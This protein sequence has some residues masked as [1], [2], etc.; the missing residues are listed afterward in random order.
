MAEAAEAL[1]LGAI[2]AFIETLGDERGSLI[3]VL[4][5]TQEKFGYLPKEAL[6][7]IADRLDV[8]L[9]SVVGV[10]TFYSQFSLTRRGRT[11]IRL[12]DGTAC[13]VS[14]AGKSIDMVQRTL[15]IKPGETSPDYEF[16]LE[17][18]YRLGACAISPVA[19]VNGQVLGRATPERVQEIINQQRT[20]AVPPAGPEAA[21]AGAAARA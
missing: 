15:K 20:P 3:P 18:V 5:Q 7:H 17:V 13:H 12:C 9:S 16:T 10:A 11:L 4:Q 8:P 14:G 21:G 6:A 2:D 1:D 19:V